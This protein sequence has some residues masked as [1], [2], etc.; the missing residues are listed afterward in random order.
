MKRKQRRQHRKHN[1][2]Q[3]IAPS[4]C[5]WRGLCFAT[6]F[7]RWFGKAATVD[8]LCIFI[9]QPA[10]AG[11]L[12]RNETKSPAKA[13]SMPIWAGGMAFTGATN[14]R[15]KPVASWKRRIKP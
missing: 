15:L 5:V 1:I 2:M 11:L 8:V 10:S 14:H 4:W 7:S 6:G 9:P 13:G 12:E 3:L